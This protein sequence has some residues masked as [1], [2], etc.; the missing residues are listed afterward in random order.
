MVWFPIYGGAA[1]IVWGDPTFLVRL[2]LRP[3]TRGVVTVL[4][5]LGPALL[6]WLAWMFALSLLLDVTRIIPELALSAGLFAVSLG[7]MAL[8]PA[9]PWQRARI[10]FRIGLRRRSAHADW[11]VRAREGPS[12]QARMFWQGCVDETR[13]LAPWAAALLA[14]F[15]YTAQ[16]QSPTILSVARFIAVSAMFIV[17]LGGASR[18]LGLPPGSLAALLCVPVPL[19]P[20]A[21]LLFAHILLW[22]ALSLFGL[23]LCRLWLDGVA[24]HRS[25]GAGLLLVLAFAFLPFS[26]VFALRERLGPYEVSW[27]SRVRAG[28]LWV[29]ASTLF[30][31]IA[32]SSP[33]LAQ[34]AIAVLVAVN[35]WQ[36]LTALP[37]RRPR[38]RT[39]RARYRSNV[40]SRG[41]APAYLR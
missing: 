1:L 33:T 26:C 9:L 27:M 41:A 18:G 6:A 3:S 31:A 22:R 29:A 15:A 17:L 35:L 32:W 34:G 39:E 4:A 30:A 8:A 10:P 7:I 14:F 19:T 38:T 2:P 16:S 37:F 36:V 13:A 5:L 11:E 20:L 28:V 21:R 40:W 12:S 23:F 24:G 25:G